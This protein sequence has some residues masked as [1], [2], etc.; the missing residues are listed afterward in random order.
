MRSYYPYLWGAIIL[1]ATTPAP[2]QE[3][4]HWQPTLDSA[5]RLAA[6][7]DRLVLAHFW[8]DWCHACKRMDREVLSQPSVVAAVHADYVPVKINA[9]YYPATCKQLG[10]SALPTDVILTPEGQVIEQLRGA[11]A[12]A[13]YRGRLAQVAARAR[14]P[15]GGAYTKVAGPPAGPSSSGSAPPY[16]SASSAGASPAAATPTRDSGG[17]AGAGSLAGPSRPVGPPAAESGRP[18]ASVGQAARAEEPLCLDGF[19]PVELC[20]RAAW[21]MGDAQYGIRHRGRTYLFAGPEHA[22]RF[23]ADPDRYAPVNSGYDVV[24]F[25]EQGKPVA[26]SRRCGVFFKDQVYLFSSEDT[27][28][29]FESDPQRYAHLLRQ[30]MQAQAGAPHGRH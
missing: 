11:S 7:T 14:G 18:N 21:V 9:D 27:R 16:A 5:R 25:L 30:A 12:A 10:V 8:A 17:G 20:E 28:A 3:A 6:Q 19:C 1:A 26:G 22:Q 2:A 24:I 23:W 13:D 4:I 15:G 29:R